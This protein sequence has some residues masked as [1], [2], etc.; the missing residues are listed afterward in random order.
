MGAQAVFNYA[1]WQALYPEFTTTVTSEQQALGY[2]AVATI[3]LR[4]DGS[5]PVTDPTVQLALL[6]MLVAH[7]AQLRVG[8]TV[9]ANSGLVGRISSA[10]QG[11]VSV[12]VDNQAPGGAAWFAQTKYGFDYWQA[13]GSYRLAG[14]TPGVRRNFNPWPGGRW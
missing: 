9:Q 12:T 4:N 14:Y 5:G 13:T 1:A 7:I 11:S 6:N 2:F 10:T 3:Y 8:S